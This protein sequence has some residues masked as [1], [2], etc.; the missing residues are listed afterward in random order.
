LEVGQEILLYL[1]TLTRCTKSAS[2]PTRPELH[3]LLST[4]FTDVGQ[5]KLESTL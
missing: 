5:R 3:P 2:H 1:D 4:D